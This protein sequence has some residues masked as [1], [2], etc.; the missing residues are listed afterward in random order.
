MTQE[1][2][3]MNACVVKLPSKYICLYPQIAALS[4]DRGASLRSGHPS[5]L[6]GTTGPSA[7]NI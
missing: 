5:M 3:Q 1:N 7:E 2:E 4:L 6:K